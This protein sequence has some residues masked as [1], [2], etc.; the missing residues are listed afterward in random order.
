L[1]N[2]AANKNTVPGDK[3]A[4]IPGGLRIGTPAMTSRGLK[5]DD[6]LKVA[7]FIDRAVQIALDEKKK[8]SSTK[9]IDFKKH[10]GNGDNVPG[11]QDLKKDV[12]SFSESFPTVGFNED[13]M[14][15]Q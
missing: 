9:L 10:I 2:I 8:V 3:S 14:T 5:E 13:E 4:L 6:F 15:Y 11:L 12:I 7:E 1:V